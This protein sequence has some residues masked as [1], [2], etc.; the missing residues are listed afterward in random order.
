MLASRS[1]L[2][3]VVVAAALGC[4]GGSNNTAPGPAPA[5]APPPADVTSAP[6]GDA[7]I[8]ELTAPP[9]VPAPI[10]RTKPAKVI[11]RLEV[12]EKELPISDGVR[13]TFWTF[14]GTVP[15]SFI[16]VRQGDMIEFHLQNHPSSKMPHNI[17][18]HAVTGPGGGAASSFTAPGHES[19]FSFRALNPGL[20]VY[21]C[22]T[23]P[24]PMHVANGMYGMILVEPAGGL[25]K[26]DREYYVMQGDFYTVGKYREKGL[27]PF[28][29]QKGIDENPTYI[30]F[31]GSEGALVGDQAL[32][33][34]VGETVRIYFGV[35][36]PNMTSSFHV[37]GEIFDRVYTE[38]GANVQEHVQTTMVPAGGATMVEFKV[39]VPGTYILVDHSLFR[40]FN[41]GAVG[42]L[43][44]EGPE[45]KLVYSGKEVD[46]VYLSDKADPS[47][48][49]AVAAAS[50]SA[51]AGTL[52]L[53]QQI[54]AGKGLFAGTCSACHQPDGKGL[55]PTFPPLDHSDYIARTPRDT[56]IGGVLNG[57]TGAV[58]V[59]GA[60]YNGLMPPM[61]HLTDD[62]IA[63][64]LT[65][66]FNS[67]GNNK[68]PVSEADVAKVR[69]S[70]PRPPGA[71]N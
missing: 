56:L 70:T 46:S 3:A 61:S 11:V 17:D 68:G 24:V 5:P 1:W 4:K 6:Q 40:A 42:M 53:D 32:T 21:H 43:K 8:A 13:Y 22:A 29:M 71:A 51:A 54:A 18:L 60:E 58:T 34:K 66:V 12:Q 35:G 41:K 30:V 45:D 25:P 55:A 36:G 14:G 47:A 59:N 62:D 50:A 57:L 23:A 65:F 44:V 26:V 48:A 67:M 28:D 52:T 64:I 20:F 15:G 9:N 69:A 7:V 37:I 27:Q 38:A 19:Q 39:Q 10:T 49:T 2:F 31:N 33:A 63:N 16:R